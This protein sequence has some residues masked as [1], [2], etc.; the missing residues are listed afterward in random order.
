MKYEIQNTKKTQIGNSKGSSG[1]PSA[2]AEPGTLALVM[3]P[4]FNQTVMI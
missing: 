2:G 1:V 3:G 4:V